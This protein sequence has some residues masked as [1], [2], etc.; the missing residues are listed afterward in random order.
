LGAD[1]A[2]V[3]L[4]TEPRRISETLGADIDL[5]SPG[6]AYERWKALPAYE[7]WQQAVE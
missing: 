2:G 4:A 3:V 1:A 5:V 7:E 6:Q